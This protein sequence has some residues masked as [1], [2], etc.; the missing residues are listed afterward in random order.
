MWSGRAISDYRKII[1]SSY[2]LYI[3]MKYTLRTQNVHWTVLLFS[4]PGKECRLLYLGKQSGFTCHIETSC[5][6][7]IGL[8]WLVDVVHYEEDRGQAL[9]E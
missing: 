8:G 4:R 2:Y 7:R 1:C 3:Y 9:L 5:A 6:A